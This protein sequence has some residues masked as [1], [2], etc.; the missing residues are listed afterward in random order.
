MA[1]AAYYGDAGLRTF[2]DADVLVPVGQA[3]RAWDLL[4]RLGYEPT[5]PLTHD[6]RS[7]DIHSIAILKS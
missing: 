3:R 5:L 4:L 6:W 1:G 7:V 2:N